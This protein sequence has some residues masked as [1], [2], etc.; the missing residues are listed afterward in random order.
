MPLKSS[1]PPTYVQIQNQFEATFS[2]PNFVK[3]ILTSYNKNNGIT[4]TT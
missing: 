3:K 4:R 2:E 1:P